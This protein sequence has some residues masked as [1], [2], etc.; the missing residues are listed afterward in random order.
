MNVIQLTKFIYL[1]R[2]LH[3]VVF[4]LAFFI[5]TLK[6]YSGPLRTYDECYYVEQSREILLTK[7]PFTMHFTLKKNFENAPLILWLNAL[8]F[9]LFGINEFTAR[10]TSA[11][12]GFLTIVLTYKL[13]KLIGGYS[14]GIL[15]SLILVTT[16]DFVRY[17][18]YAHLDS[19]LTFFNT[20]SIYLFFKFLHYSY[21]NNKKTFYLFYSGLSAGLSILSKS[22][23]GIFSM[24]LYCIF[25]IFNL[26]YKKY[27]FSF[28][29]LL[30]LILTTIFLPTLWYIYQ[31]LVNGFDFFKIHFGYIIFQRAF[32]NEIEFTPWYHYIK[33][34]INTYL[35]WNIFLFLGIIYLIIKSI[36]TY[37]LNLSK[38]NLNYNFLYLCLIYILIYVFILSISDAKKGWYLMP[39]Y[40]FLAIITA[41]CIKIILKS[42]KL[43]FLT[44]NLKIISNFIIFL[45]LIN[46]LLSIL[47]ISLYENSNLCYKNELSNFKKI[48]KY[49]PFKHNFTFQPLEFICDEYDYKLPIA[50]Y[51][52]IN[53]KSSI[54]ISEISNKNN[55][56][57][58]Y[59]IQTEKL[60]LINQNNITNEIEII[61]K[62][63]SFTIFKLK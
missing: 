21:I 11:I 53:P 17:S 1:K 2:K 56:K 48:V 33:I 35:P 6:L 23:L 57:I 61:I 47:P 28:N 52:G 20:L 22:L 9:K 31:Y 24:T 37:N 43:N 45:A 62:N 7:N 29:N 30:I 10:I 38:I 59:F 18:R 39:I 60:S 13:A 44:I 58:Y 3:I 50:F 15:S 54:K 51:L 34:I 63:P 36:N 49:E 12:F 27:N 5:F 19:G 40:P 8:I 55:D 46:T 42:Y 16:F 26:F 25:Y 14:F 4:I 41:Y 32:N